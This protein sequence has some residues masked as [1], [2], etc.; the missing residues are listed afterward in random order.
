MNKI[1]ITFLSLFLTT[2]AS[3][4][5]Y[6]CKQANGTIKYSSMPCPKSAKIQKISTLN[7][8]NREDL[9]AISVMPL[10]KIITAK[11]ALKQIR[12]DGFS[13]ISFKDLKKK[14]KA[15]ENINKQFHFFKHAFWEHKLDIAGYPKSNTI[16]FYYYISG[17]NYDLF[18][19]PEKQRGENEKDRSVHFNIKLKNVNRHAARLG[20]KKKSEYAHSLSWK[21]KKEGFK[22]EMESG[23]TAGISPHS[24]SLFCEYKGKTN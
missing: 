9:K 21:W 15:G 11:D 22:C 16:S 17:M 5:I 4:G 7:H 10:E 20:F 12:L 6:K 13:E 1:I 19:D 2:I 14:F 3:A 8:T 24:L 18:D 23:I